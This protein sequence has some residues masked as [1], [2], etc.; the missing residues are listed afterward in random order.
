MLD[1]RQFLSHTAA[2]LGF[3]LAAGYPLMAFDQYKKM[4]S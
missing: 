3:A 1:R 4:P 2:G